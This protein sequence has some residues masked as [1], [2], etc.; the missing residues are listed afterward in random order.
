MK[1]RLCSLMKVLKECIKDTKDI[2]EVASTVYKEEKIDNILS[3]TKQ[4]K[5][6]HGI[7]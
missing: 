3:D 4:I 7:E 1:H 2:D 6:F 5:E